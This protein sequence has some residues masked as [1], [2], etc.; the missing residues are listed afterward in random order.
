MICPKCKIEYREGFDKCSDCGCNLVEGKTDETNTSGS[1]NNILYLSIS[2][3]INT[4]AGLIG[5]LVVAV[6]AFFYFPSS[7]GIFMLAYTP[8]L[9]DKMI[10][11][12]ILFIYLFM[13]IIVNYV[14]LKLYK[15]NKVKYFLL[16]MLYLFAVFAVVSYNQLPHRIIRNGISG[17]KY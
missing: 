11:V 5:F 9:K 8:S 3:I 6:S 1:I 17:W 16:S 13:V 12:S 2:F 4:L 14:V 15:G 10:G 7:G